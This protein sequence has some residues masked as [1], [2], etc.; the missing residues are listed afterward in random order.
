MSVHETN[1]S[2][3]DLGA[4][5][6]LDARRLVAESGTPLL[7]PQTATD[8]IRHYYEFLEGVHE[9]YELDP[10]EIYEFD[11]ARGAIFRE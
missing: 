5:R 2:G 8:W 9:R 4:L 3:Q 1:M 6:E 11:C 7:D 10:E